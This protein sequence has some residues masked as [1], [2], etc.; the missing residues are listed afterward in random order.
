MAALLFRRVKDGSIDMDRTDG[1][2]VRLTKA[3][4]LA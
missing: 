1:H 3:L 4:V 2:H